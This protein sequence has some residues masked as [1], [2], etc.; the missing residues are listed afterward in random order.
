MVIENWV[1]LEPG[2]PKRLHFKDHVIAS[3]QITDPIRGVPATRQGL[4]F[5]VDEEDGT[6][7]DK[8]YSVL[9]EKHA[10]DFEGYLPD[11]RYLGYTFVI[12]KDAPGFV[13]P[14]IL[15]TRA[16]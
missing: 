12:I 2:R 1:K 10:S 8:M 14:R 11:K 7:V 3:R 9:S 16:R 15:E 5:Y 4:I 6:R 13:P